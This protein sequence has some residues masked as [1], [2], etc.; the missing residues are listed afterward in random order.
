M[1]IYTIFF[2]FEII[3]FEGLGCDSYVVCCVIYCGCY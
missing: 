2:F 1:A 3:K